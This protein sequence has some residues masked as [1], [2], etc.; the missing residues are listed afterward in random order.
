MHPRIHGSI[1]YDRGDPEHVKQAKDNNFVDISLVVANLYDFGKT[2]NDPEKTVDQKVENT[3]IGGPTMLM[4]GIKNHKHVGVV[5]NPSSYADLI[6][7]M[8]TNNGQLTESTRMALAVDA[9]NQIADYRDLNA[10]GI[11][12][13][14]G[15]EGNKETLRLA[16]ECGEEKR[17]GEN[18][19][20]RSTGFRKRGLNPNLPSVANCEIVGGK[21]MSHNNDLDVEAALHAIN[22]LVRTDSEGNI[23]PAVSLGKHTNPCGYATG[24]DLKTAIDAAW[25]GDR[26]SAFGGIMATTVPMDLEAAQ[27]LKGRFVEIIIA[28]GYTPEALEYLQKKNAETRLL[29]NPNATLKG[30]EALANEL[31]I[32]TITGGALRQTRDTEPYAKW[33][34]MTKTE[35]DPKYDGLAKFGIAANKNTKSNTIS[36]VYEYAEGQYM[37]L[38]MG[39]GQPNRVDS[40]R[41]LAVTKALENIENMYIDG[42]K[43]R[44]GMKQGTQLLADHILDMSLGDAKKYVMS[45]TVLVSDAFFPFADSVDSANEFGIK[46]ILQPGGSKKDDEVIAACDKYGIS[47]KFTERR[48]FRH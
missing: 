26:V 22:D 13:W 8:V 25:E 19:H 24:A 43:I 34:T 33:E 37:Q 28:P 31:D 9:I 41:K 47:M 30:V 42:L 14:L 32:R 18:S 21:Q 1:G 39:A 12:K 20:Q 27:K 3:D 7:E 46:R 35:W 38:G 44:A 48:H 29:I 23:L 2:M 5:M 10:M 16:F 17:Y 40:L 6:E 11:T 4:M 45:Q 36:L 15:N